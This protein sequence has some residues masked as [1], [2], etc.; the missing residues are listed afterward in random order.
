MKQYV[1]AFAGTSIAMVS[2]DMLWLGIIATPLYRQGIGH[3]MAD[4]PDIGV[5]LLFYLLYSMGVVIFAVSPRAGGSS[6]TRPTRRS[7]S[8]K[9]WSISP[10]CCCAAMNC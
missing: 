2:L 3:L 9:A 10:N 8:A 1:A 6:C 4:S 5:A 7:A